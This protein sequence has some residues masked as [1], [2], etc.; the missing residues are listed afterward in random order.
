MKKMS[1]KRMLES[2]EDGTLDSGL[3]R[4]GTNASMDLFNLPEELDS[5]AIAG[6]V[7][8][9]QEMPEISTEKDIIEAL[10]A[11][12]TSSTMNEQVRSE[13]SGEPGMFLE[14]ELDLDDKIKRFHQMALVPSMYPS[15]IEH[16]APNLLLRLL[17]HPNEDIGIEVLRV[18]GDMT[19]ESVLEQ[20]DDPDGFLLSLIEECDAPVGMSNMLS[21][22]LQSSDASPESALVCLEAIGNLMDGY[23]NCHQDFSSAG[24]CEVLLVDLINRKSADLT[25]T[26]CVSYSLEIVFDLVQSLGVSCV[27]VKGLDVV[28]NELKKVLE[29]DLDKTA[30]GAE[31]R[32]NLV[33][34]VVL[35]LGQRTT[36]KEY[37]SDK[38]AIELFVSL[39]RSSSRE[40]IAIGLQLSSVCTIDSPK[41]CNAFIDNH[42]LRVI[43]SLLTGKV[44]LSKDPN[45]T[46]KHQE[47]LLGLVYTLLKDSDDQEH[48]S[49]V[50][51]KLCENSLEKSVPLV[52]IAAQLLSSVPPSCDAAGVDKYLE[53]CDKG[54]LRL[55][56]ACLIILTVFG[57][58]GGA[59]GTKN[60]LIERINACK[61]NLQD[62]M[63][64]VFEYMQL[65]NQETAQDELSTIQRF[66]EMFQAE[67]I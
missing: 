63:Q 33:D 2:A 53:R 61:I 51:A 57:S 30:L 48:R 67:V 5:S 49:R 29:Q 19:D 23:P 59:S 3:V 58:M 26:Y 44:I 62:F 60:A 42:G 39:F 54:L 35:L 40:K 1:L 47:Y 18:F 20:V 11:L 12:E 9:A 32:Q 65:R 34:V 28:L 46:G 31:C 15:F 45:E 52:D 7:E 16:R 10:L 64:I 37:F 21:R 41:E 4:V 38:R 24:L 8:K 50:L 13:H 56:W 66:L 22:I 43:G 27:P 55:Q 36:S 14:S 17:D 6:I 25:W